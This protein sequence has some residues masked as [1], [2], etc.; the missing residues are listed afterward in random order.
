MVIIPHRQYWDQVVQRE[1]L[2]GD[3]CGALYLL[4]LSPPTILAAVASD[5]FLPALQASGGILAPLL[6]GASPA[7]MVWCQRYGK[8]GHSNG[9]S[10]DDDEVGVNS[11]GYDTN[12][13]RLREKNEFV[14]GGRFALGF[15]LVA[16]CGLALQSSIGAASL[17]NVAAA[18]SGG[19]P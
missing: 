14:P 1:R 15:L 7:A 3:S 6:Y 18:A 13:K 17:V 9:N 19:T 8:S 11:V 5:L 16:S 4:A 12:S 2:L 10:A